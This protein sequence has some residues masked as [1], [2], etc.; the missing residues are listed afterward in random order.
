MR[1]I[2][3]LDGPSGVAEATS[4]RILTNTSGERVSRGAAALSRAVG[5]QTEPYKSC[6]QARRSTL[7]LAPQ[8]LDGQLAPDAPGATLKARASGPSRIS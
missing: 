4:S 2:G 8:C 6:R 1:S 3:S 5:G 7:C